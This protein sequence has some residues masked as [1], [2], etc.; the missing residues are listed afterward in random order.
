MEVK[1][2]KAFLYNTSVSIF[3]NQGA[4]NVQFQ[5]AQNVKFPKSSFFTRCPYSWSWIDTGINTNDFFEQ[6]YI[7]FGL[8]VENLDFS[9]NFGNYKGVFPR[10]YG[11]YTTELTR[12]LDCVIGQNHDFLQIGSEV[13]KLLMNSRY[14]LHMWK[15]QF[16]RITT[17][18]FGWFSSK[19]LNNFLP[20]GGGEGIWKKK[21]FFQGVHDSSIYISFHIWP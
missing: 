1:Y 6:F 14:N 2:I 20:R 7:P 10:V 8:Y 19:Y 21:K 5:G 13:S 11:R 9:K 18:K 15:E 17:P 3:I 16:Q 4:Q 12:L